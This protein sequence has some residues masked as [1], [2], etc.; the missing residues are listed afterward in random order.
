MIATEIKD[1]GQVIKEEH[2]KLVHVNLPQGKVIPAHDHLDHEIYFTIV[3]GEVKTI[4][5][6]VE[7]HH[8]SPGT[9]LSF[10]GE[11]TISIEALVDSEFFVSLV[12]R[13]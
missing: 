2:F 4:L 3:R 13:P 8:L 1:F 11:A 7:E 6:G 9:V 12:K 5:D 10:P